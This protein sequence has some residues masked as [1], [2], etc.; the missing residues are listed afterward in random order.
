MI[1]GTY[2]LNFVK[3][4][5]DIPSDKKFIIDKNEKNV[6]K[7]EVDTINEAAIYTKYLNNGGY[8]NFSVYSGNKKSLSNLKVE[9]CLVDLTGDGIEELLFKIYDSS[10][11][12]PRGYWTDTALLTLDE[13]LNV[14]IRLIA[15]FTGGTAGGD[16]LSLK[17]D[18]KN[19]RY[20]V[21][22][23][24][25]AWDAIWANVRKIICNTLC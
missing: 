13:N 7:V 6:G 1:L 5:I 14:K 21:A 18:A 15:E 2:T 3:D 16:T 22:C 25:R 12:G 8:Y 17:F 10:F 24:S 9:S 11:A 19:N 20:V 23:D 4:N